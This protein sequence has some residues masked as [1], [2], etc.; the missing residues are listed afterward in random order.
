VDSLDVIDTCKRPISLQ[1]HLYQ[2]CQTNL[3]R[4]PKIIWYGL[5]FHMTQPTSRSIIKPIACSK[6]T[7]S[8]H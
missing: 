1:K 3:F 6:P 7:I 8:K 4:D 2:V 5:L